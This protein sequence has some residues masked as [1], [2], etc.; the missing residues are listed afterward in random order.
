M[1]QRMPQSV[2]E[3]AAQVREY[4]RRTVQLVGAHLMAG[5]VEGAN[6]V[7]D[8]V[9]ANAGRGLHD[10]ILD[11]IARRFGQVNWRIATNTPVWRPYE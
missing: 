11:D 3:A 5:D 6:E 4:M 8:T 9:M 1:G 10:L 7:M 2:Q